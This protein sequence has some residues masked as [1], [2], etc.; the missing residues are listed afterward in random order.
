[1]SLLKK[2]SII[3]GLLLSASHAMADEV[4]INF[5]TDTGSEAVVNGQTAPTEVGDIFT[6][7]DHQD[8]QRIFDLVLQTAEAA[9]LLGEVSAHIVN[10]D[11]GTT[12]EIVFVIEGEESSISLI[13]TFAD[14]T[15][16]VWSKGEK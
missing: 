7:D 6:P 11:T 15:K 4:D 1:M 12:K 9:N 3:F 8:A 2:L 10:H 5:T 16:L 14:G 13:G